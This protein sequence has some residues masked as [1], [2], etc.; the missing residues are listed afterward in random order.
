MTLRSQASCSAVRSTACGVWVRLF[1]IRGCM[2]RSSK[3]PLVSSV[4]E[5]G[6]VIAKGRVTEMVPG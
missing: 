6:V 2:K 5:R 4:R 3:E 1:K